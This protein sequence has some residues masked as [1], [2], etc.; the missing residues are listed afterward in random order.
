MRSLLV[1]HNGSKLD[2]NTDG[3]ITD[4]YNKY[5][6]EKNIIYHVQTLPPSLLYR[7]M[8]K[9]DDIAIQTDFEQVHHIKTFLNLINRIDCRPINIFVYYI[10]I[11]E[12]LQTL[13]NIDELDIAISNHN[14]FELYEHTTSKFEISFIEDLKYFKLQQQKY[15]HSVEKR[16]HDYT[17]RKIKILDLLAVNEETEYLINGA[18]V[19]ELNCDDMDSKLQEG[20]W[21]WGKNCPIKL[22]NKSHHKEYE[23]IETTL[24]DVIRNVIQ[25]FSN[26]TFEETKQFVN[27]IL[28]SKL[29]CNTKAYLIT[30]FIGINDAD[31]KAYVTSVIMMH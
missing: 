19:T 30:E 1:L 23:I 29:D 12:K 18:I 3:C 26:D 15:N 17:G 2:P 5:P 27:K 21:I 8:L 13:Y 24:D 31:N 11:R 22:I 28:N 7:L 6:G 16:K 14:I 20:V 25:I 9:C 4:F 10:G